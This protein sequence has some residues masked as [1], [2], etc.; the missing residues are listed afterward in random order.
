MWYWDIFVVALGIH[1][2]ML[3]IDLFQPFYLILVGIF[4]LAV[5]ATTALFRKW[6]L[7]GNIYFC[8]SSTRLKFVITNWLCWSASRK[9]AHNLCVTTTNFYIV[10]SKRNYIIYVGFSRRHRYLFLNNFLKLGNSVTSWP[11]TWYPIVFNP[12]PY[13]T[14]RSLVIMVLVSNHVNNIQGFFG[15]F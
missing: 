1:F 15:K 13:L 5:I 4:L 3:V 2:L 10:C 7:K 14:T 8:C 11:R 9:V 12:A 6:H